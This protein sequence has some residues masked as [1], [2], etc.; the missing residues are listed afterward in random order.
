MRTKSRVTTSIIAVAV[1]AMGASC[2]MKSS[3]T[4]PSFT[5]E[6][7]PIH[8]LSVQPLVGD[9][10]NEQPIVAAVDL[11]GSAR[12]KS[13]DAKF[14]AENGIV[15]ARDG[16]G[17]VAYHN[18]GTT[19]GGIYVLVVTVSSGGSGIFED[20]LWVKI[21]QDRVWENGKS[22]ERTMLMR[23]GQIA[24]GDRDDGDVRLDGSNLF[25][26]KSRYR[27]RDAIIPL[28]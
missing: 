23:V 9:L 24:L 1:T 22:R 27:E 21:A 14:T 26:G 8:P 2:A 18:I 4:I 13:N 10:A 12:S 15:M 20:V 11:E 16:D 7:H 28:Q 3:E 17:Y 19:R 6:A 5:F 25:I